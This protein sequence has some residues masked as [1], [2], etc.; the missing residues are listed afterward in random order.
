MRRRIEPADA[1][2]VEI[3]LLRP[4]RRY[5]VVAVARARRVAARDRAVILRVNSPGGSVSASDQIWYQVDKLSNA[6][7]P[8]IA[9]FGGL[10]ASGGYYV[11][12][13]ADKIIAEPT[14]ITEG[15]PRRSLT[16]RASCRRPFPSRPGALP[17]NR[18]ISPTRVA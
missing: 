6:G 9:S 2:N 12:C 5:G 15:A 17:T 11:A 16:P 4:V 3:V 13:A 7:L 1:L 14:T 8:V 10:A 18:A